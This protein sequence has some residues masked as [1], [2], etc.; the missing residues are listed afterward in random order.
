MSQVR[1]VTCVS[2]LD[3]AKRGAQEGI[4]LIA[5]QLDYVRSFLR[6]F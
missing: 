5:H 4:A 6:D 3:K 2:G 1:F